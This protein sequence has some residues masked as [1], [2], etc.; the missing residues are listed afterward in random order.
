MEYKRMQAEID[1]VNLGLA[2]VDKELDRLQEGSPQFL[3]GSRET[4]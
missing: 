2:E 3:V 1:D 4:Q